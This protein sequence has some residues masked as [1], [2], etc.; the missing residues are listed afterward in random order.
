MKMEI[1]INQTK[2]IF[3]RDTIALVRRWHLIDDKN[4]LI[5]I[6]GDA[7]EFMIYKIIN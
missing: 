3:N 4:V 5:L 6:E 2:E 1:I 7:K